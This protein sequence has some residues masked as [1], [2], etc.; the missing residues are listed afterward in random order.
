MNIQNIWPIVNLITECIRISP[1][2]SCTRHQAKTGAKKAFLR[3]CSNALGGRV[4]DG[5]VWYPPVVSVSISGARGMRW[6]SPLG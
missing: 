4:C 3:R 5:G 6:W 2:F 1:H